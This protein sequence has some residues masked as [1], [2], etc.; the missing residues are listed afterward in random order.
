MAQRSLYFLCFFLVCSCASIP[1]PIEE[2]SLAKAAF[3]AAVAS[4]SAKYA[5]QLFYKAEKAYKRGEKL[6]K[7][8]D[9]EEAKRQFVA[10]R[11]LAEKAEDMSRIKQ[12]NSGDEGAEQ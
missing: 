11:K 5:P 3:D 8:R 12:F 4:E 2:Y 7:E 9:Y 10:S 1:I 6:Y